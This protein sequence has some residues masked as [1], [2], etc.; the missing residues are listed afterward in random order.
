[1]KPI[2]L[3]LILQYIIGST[4]AE[5]NST[6]DSD[7]VALGL[8]LDKI[9]ENHTSTDN[10][11]VIENIKW[12]TSHFDA[13]PNALR[14]LTSADTQKLERIYAKSSGKE[15]LMA[16]SFLAEIKDIDS[17]HPE[18]DKILDNGDNDSLHTV[19][20]LVDTKLVEGSPKEK[21]LLSSR[22]TLLRRISNLREN[23]L[24]S[25]SVLQKIERISLLSERYNSLGNVDPSELGQTNNKGTEQIEGTKTRRYW[26]YIATT[27][28][29]F[30]LLFVYR[31]F[32]R[33]R[34]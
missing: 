14:K 29:L 1:M 20:T 17:W 31:K 7:L 9:V 8:A 15:R 22:A 10:P 24:D 23:F 27:I 33:I 32:D 30:G 19:I 18:L 4:Y 11:E 6:S 3:I 2:I 13:N 21:A 28:L 5:N 16:F 26:K 25:D 12:M 34:N